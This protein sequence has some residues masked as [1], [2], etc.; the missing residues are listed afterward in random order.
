MLLA[1]QAC[2]TLWLPHHPADPHSNA[3]PAFVGFAS[4]DGLVRRSRAFLT[5]SCVHIPS[6]AG[7]PGHAVSQ[8]SVTMAGI[9]CISAL[10][11]ISSMTLSLVICLYHNPAAGN[12]EASQEER[13]A[14]VEDRN[15]AEDQ[16]REVVERLAMESP[17]AGEAGSP[18]EESLVGPRSP[19]VREEVALASL[20]EVL[21]MVAEAEQIAAAVVEGHFDRRHSA[22]QDARS[23]MVLAYWEC[24]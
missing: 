4:L 16:N 3:L 7:R 11:A 8:H 14:L 19:P 22:P 21:A 2:N 9:L 10:R 5:M 1:G 23:C 13:L 6:A 15:R 24:C 17:A 20:M 18:L 12:P